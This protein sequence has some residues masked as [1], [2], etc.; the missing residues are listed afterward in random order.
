MRG[1]RLL[2]VALGLGLVLGCGGDD[3]REEPR[4]EQQIRH[5]LLR[6]A[7]AWQN[8]DPGPFHAYYSEA[9]DFDEVGKQDHLDSIFEDFPYIRDWRLTGYNVDVVSADLALAEMHFA[10]SLH[11]DISALDNPETVEEWV[12]SRNVLLQVWQRDFDGVWRVAAE[13]LAEAWV[14]GDSPRINDFSV[15]PGDEFTAGLAHGISADAEMP[16]SRYRVTLWPDC[17]AAEG[18]DPEWADGWRGVGYYGDFVVRDDAWGEYALSFIGQADRPPGTTMIG[19][20]IDA[21]YIVVVSR[22]GQKPARQHRAPTGVRKSVFRLLRIH[23]SADQNRC[24]EPR[25]Q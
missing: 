24:P 6:L 18:F 25:P 16:D 19:R 7:A 2:A 15:E 8:E 11:A 12:E 9:Y 21:A 13:Y 23:G 1:A 14:M 10:M 22:S 20:R 17:F 5:N 3:D 4:P